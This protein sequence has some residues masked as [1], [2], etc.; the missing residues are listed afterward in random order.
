M[1]SGHTVTSLAFQ[2]Q[3]IL[4]VL[5][6]AVAAAAPLLAQSLAVPSLAWWPKPCKGVHLAVSQ[7]YGPPALPSHYG[8][9]FRN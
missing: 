5:V 7:Q 3:Q 6:P 1:M 8:F 9:A 2:T 4:L